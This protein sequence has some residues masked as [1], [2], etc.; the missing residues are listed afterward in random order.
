MCVCVCYYIMCIEEELP[1]F[2]IDLSLLK[3]LRARIKIAKKIDIEDHK[4]VHKV[5]LVYPVF[6][7]GYVRLQEIKTGLREQP[8]LWTLYWMKTCK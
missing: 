4:Y 1:N 8:K 2:P 7:S 3:P 5:K 6:I